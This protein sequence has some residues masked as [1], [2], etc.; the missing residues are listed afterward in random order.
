MRLNHSNRETNFYNLNHRIMKQLL[1]LAMLAL[2]IPSAHAQ[3]GDAALG[4]NII[5][6]RTGYLDLNLE[7]LRFSDYDELVISGDINGDDIRALRNVVGGSYGLNY[8]RDVN[9]EMWKIRRLNL[10]NAH[11]VTGGGAYMIAP[12]LS[13]EKL[14]CADDALG[15]YMFYNCQNLEELVLPRCTQ[16]GAMLFEKTPLRQIELPEGTEDFGALS[17]FSDCI[18][19]ERLVLPSTLKHFSYSTMYGTYEPV[20]MSMKEFVVKATEVPAFEYTSDGDKEE[21]ARFTLVVPVGSKEKYAAAEGWKDFGTIVEADVAQQVK[22]VSADSA[23]STA[24]YDLQGRRV[25][26]TTK[27]GVYVRNG[28]KVVIK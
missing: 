21:V 8:V 10:E 7:Y 22:T 3:Q 19:L 16:Y 27:P 13:T 18:T 4:E 25:T 26:D 5:D 6:V 17:A 11:I 15:S 28:K 1:T 2:C 12:H 14:F 24:T 23:E 9:P 20:M